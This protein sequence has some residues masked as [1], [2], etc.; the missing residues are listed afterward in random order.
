MPHLRT[1]RDFYRALQELLET[2]QASTRPLET[3]LRALLQQ[4]APWKAAQALPLSA[5]YDLLAAAFTA[6]PAPFEDAWRSSYATLPPA[7]RGYSRWQAILQGQIVDLREME[8][9]GILKD[10]YRYFG[11]DAPRGG[12]WYNFDPFTYLECG[13]AGAV[14]GWDPS[15]EAAGR[16]FVPGPVAVLDEDGSVT[17]RNPED[18][19]HPEVEIP[20]MTWDLFTDF[21]CCG[22][23]YE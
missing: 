6:P 12:R 3:Y 1:N 17:T 23:M 8:E 22:Q 9:Q 7:I 18:V 4:A 10:P 14:G 2:Q 11:I 5:C 15:Q 21:L 13:A 16:S 19:P 20:V